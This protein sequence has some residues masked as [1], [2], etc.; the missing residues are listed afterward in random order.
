MRGVWN[1]TRNKTTRGTFTPL[2]PALHYNLNTEDP[3]YIQILQPAEGFWYKR[4]S[5]IPSKGLA[6]DVD[7]VIVIYEGPLA[8]FYGRQYFLVGMYESMTYIILFYLLLAWQCVVLYYVLC[9]KSI[10]WNVKND[11][12]LLQIIP[13]K[14]HIISYVAT[15]YVSKL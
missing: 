8:G 2:C 1:M 13:T 12:L 4:D 3:G 7:A 14:I 6:L 5:L 9:T 10:W 11:L 15:Y